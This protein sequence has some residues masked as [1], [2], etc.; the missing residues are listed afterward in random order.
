[1]DSP[2]WTGHLFSLKVGLHL[3]R[4]VGHSILTMSSTALSQLNI[5]AGQFPGLLTLL[6]LHY[7]T[8]WNVL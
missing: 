5:P 4:V 2:D 6:S 7:L 8:P 3:P 1:M